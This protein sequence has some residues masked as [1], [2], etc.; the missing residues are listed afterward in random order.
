VLLLVLAGGTWFLLNDGNRGRDGTA[1]G[2][3]TSQTSAAPTGIELSAAFI[4]RPADEVQ[5]ELEAAGLVVRQEEAGE[6]ALASSGQALDAGDVAALDPS[7]G[8]AGPGTEV[9]L[10]VAGDAFDPDAGD[11]EPTATTESTTEARPTETTTSTTTTTSSAETTTT[12]PPVS[13]P[14]TEE[15]PPSSDPE[16]SPPAD[17]AEAPAAD[18]VG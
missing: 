6:E 3:S 16:E 18:G 12:S 17:N 14:G 4:G 1:A 15:P 5:T 9:V 8:F 13:L 7:S 10:F 11:D 2:T